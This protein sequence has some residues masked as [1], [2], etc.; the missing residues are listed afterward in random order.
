MV[1]CA[2]CYAADACLAAAAARGVLE[3]HEIRLRALPARPRQLNAFCLRAGI[4]EPLL[5]AVAIPGNPTASIAGEMAGIEGGI[6][7]CGYP[8]HSFK[9]SAHAWQRQ[10][11]P[12]PIDQRVGCLPAY[13]A[14]ETLRPRSSLALVSG[15]G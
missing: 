12:G 9:A 6:G 1:G 8:W 3:E 13:A 14:V 15:G 5:G 10:G 11:N 7:V 4:G 2:R